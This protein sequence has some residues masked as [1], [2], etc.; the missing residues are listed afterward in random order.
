MMYKKVGN[1]KLIEEEVVEIKIL[2]KKGLSIPVLANMFG[3][4]EKSIYNIKYFHTW[5]HVNR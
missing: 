2:L 5:R 3:V 4:A 1:Q